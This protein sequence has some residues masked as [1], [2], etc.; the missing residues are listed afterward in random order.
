MKKTGLLLLLLL[1]GSAQAAVF[2]VRVVGDNG[3]PIAG[4]AVCIG[5]H[6]NYRQFAALFTS[7]TGNVSVEVPN[8]P[9]VITV[10]KDRFSGMRLA[11][12][13]REY[14][15]VKEIR[16]LEGV[17]GPRCRAGSSLASMTPSVDNRSLVVN[18][19]IVED[20]VYSLSLITDVTGEPSHYRISASV[21]FTDA[22]WMRYAPS[23]QLSQKLL[24]SDSVFMQ[25]RRFKS[26]TSGWIE[27]RSD[28]ISIDLPKL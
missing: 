10:S 27:A 4:A 2:G 6:G 19:V 11:E 13:A 7:T 26:L 9:L 22:R 8:V 20:G 5:T 21:D 15:L 16:L 25:I 17:P 23:I 3:E 12:P 24:D 28:V 14:N 18:R 1:V